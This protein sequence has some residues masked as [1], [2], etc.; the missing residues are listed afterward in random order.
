VA[1]KDSTARLQQSREA[2]PASVFLLI[3]LLLLLAIGAIYGGVALI[4]D[5]TG[6]LLG[7]PVTLLAGRP[8]PDYLLPG[9]ILFGLLG[10]FPVA[11][12]LG[13]WFRPGWGWA[14][15]FAIHLA[16]FAALAVGV[17]LIVWILVQMA[18]L[19]FFLQPILLALGIAIIG[20]S[21]LPGVRRYYVKP[22]VSESF[23]A[24]GRERR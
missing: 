9:I 13:L 12:A 24:P 7:M 23:S 20:V 8:F 3:V 6:G 1:Q 11:V 14:P 5:P 19:R 4:A 22:E 10:V 18:I 17:A 16:W 15:G 21:L 2:R